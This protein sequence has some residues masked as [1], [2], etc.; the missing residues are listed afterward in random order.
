M[1]RDLG[2]AIIAFVLGYTVVMSVDVWGELPKSQIDSETIEQAIAR[3]IAEHDS[4]PAAHLGATGS[5]T[6]H[7]T[8]G[9][10]DHLAGSIPADKVSSAEVFI[11]DQFMTLDGW[12]IDYGDAVA[13]GY[14][15]ILS[16]NSVNSIAAQVINDINSFVYTTFFDKD[17]LLQFV[18]RTANPA[19]NPVLYGYFGAPFVG[20]ENGFGIKVES[21]GVIFYV[22]QNSVYTYSPKY[23]LDPT[24]NHIYRMHVSSVD[25]LIGFYV[26]G[27]LIDSVSVSTQTINDFSTLTF[28]HEG[29]N[30]VY[31][32]SY[33]GDLI[34]AHDL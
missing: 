13:S 11:R 18:H 28:R 21:D 12:T 7:R 4:D 2:I 34:F 33:I 6:A 30:G 26:D 5:L 19:L 17:I 24:N 3:I 8:S 29:D 15:M 32:L 1:Y 31:T 25:G 16:K 14:M 27:E 9:I 10:L 20:G 23:F 22:V